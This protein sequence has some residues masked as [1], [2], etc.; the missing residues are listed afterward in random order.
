[1]VK[2]TEAELR[3]LHLFNPFVAALLRSPLHG[4][5]SSRLMLLT[6]TGRKSGRTYTIPVGYT[7]L[8]GDLLVFTY[9]AWWRNLRGGGS[10]T[11]GLQG[12]TMIARAEVIEAPA[13]VVAEV[14]R[15][16]ATLGAREAYTRV[17]IKLA[18]TP[19]PTRDEL[20]RALAGIVVVRVTPEP[21]SER[22]SA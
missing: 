5:V 8:G 2:Y 16:I 9:Y 21:S 14:E 20:A 15:L 6:Y 18:T 10:V 11:L 4:L 7:R 1:V 3:V 13:H 17:G 22:P 19:L 12:R